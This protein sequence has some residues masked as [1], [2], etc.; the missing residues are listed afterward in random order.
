MP[1][2]TTWVGL[3]IIII[4]EDRQRQISHDTTNMWNLKNKKKYK[5]TYLQNRNG[6]TDS[7]NRLEITKG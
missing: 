7:K 4:S 2:E 6:L 1:F 3:E 5:W